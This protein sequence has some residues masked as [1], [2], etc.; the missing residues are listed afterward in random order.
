[1]NV[2]TNSIITD[3]PSTRMPTSKSMPPDCHQVQVFSTGG[4]T[5]CAS[6]CSPPSA[7]VPCSSAVVPEV[8]VAAA[9]WA[10]PV[11]P[12][13]RVPS[14]VGDCAAAPAADSPGPP[15]APTAGD[16]DSTAAL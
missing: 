9:P 7:E 5:T 1:M 13:L 6:S 14:V 2:T 10:D 12:V 11:L 3:R 8:V 16:V 15:T 4:M